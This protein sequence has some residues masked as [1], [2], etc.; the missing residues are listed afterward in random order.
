MTTLVEP[1]T[2]TIPLPRRIVP[3]LAGVVS[4]LVGLATTFALV[5]AMGTGAARAESFTYWSLWI[6]EDGTWAAAS[7][8]ASDLKLTDES[9]FAAKYLE[10]DAE[11]TKVDAPESSSDYASLCPELQPEDGQVR[12]AVVLDFGD[13][14]LAPGGQ[15]PPENAVK[16]V[17]VAEPVTAAGALEAASSVTADSAGFMTAIDGYPG[18][19]DAD[20]GEGEASTSSDQLVAEPDD[21]TNAWFMGGL[22]LVVIVGLIAFVVMRNKKNDD[23]DSDDALRD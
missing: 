23:G 11:L 7:M 1:K 12:V 16:C 20:T 13:P 8:G 21:G 9:A 22:A 4:A 2:R 15:T 6:V 19:E 5:L 14:N 17:L 18:L 3:A 10:S